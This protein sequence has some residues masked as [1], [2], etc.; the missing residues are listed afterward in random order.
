ME[1]TDTEETTTEKRYEERGNFK[2]H[3]HLPHLV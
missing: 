3:Y 2:R 1:A